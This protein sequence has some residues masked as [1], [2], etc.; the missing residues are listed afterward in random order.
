MLSVLA[1]FY[2]LESLTQLGRFVHGAES[3]TYCFDDL[4]GRL[5]RKNPQ[6]VK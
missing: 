2:V 6:T 3:G 4:D 1:P 5:L